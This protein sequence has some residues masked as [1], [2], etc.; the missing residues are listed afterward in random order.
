MVFVAPVTIHD[1]AHGGRR[2]LFNVAKVGEQV[3]DRGSYGGFRGS[4]KPKKCHAS[5][6]TWDRLVFEVDTMFGIVLNT[7]VGHGIDPTA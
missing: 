5:V 3:P 4:V 7:S 1:F 6:F 2:R